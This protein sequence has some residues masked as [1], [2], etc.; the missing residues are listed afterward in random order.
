VLAADCSVRNTL[1]FASNP[2]CAAFD[3]YRSAPNL[4]YS[5]FDTWL[6]IPLAD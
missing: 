2:D 1:S 4:N 6:F 3:S 5:M